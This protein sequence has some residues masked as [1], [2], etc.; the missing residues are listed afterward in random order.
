MEQKICLDTTFLISFLRG[1]PESSHFINSTEQ[2]ARLATTS[3]NLFELYQGAYKSKYAENELQLIN[4]LK[5]KLLVLPFSEK[6]AQFA[7]MIA[8]TLKGNPIEIRDLFIAAIAMTKNYAIKTNNKKHF[9]RI[10]GLI[11]L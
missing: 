11:V 1:N 4:D 2:T 9:E 10:P 6:N 8:A 5:Q 7:G 3:I